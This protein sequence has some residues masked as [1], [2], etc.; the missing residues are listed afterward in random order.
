MMNKWHAWV[1]EREKECI[2]FLVIHDWE[3]IDNKM[4]A[5]SNDENRLQYFKS[6]IGKDFAKLRGK[7]L[8]F[9]CICLNQTIKNK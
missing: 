3:W 5:V 9:W 2:L 6:T 1:H 8:A 4:I 7:C